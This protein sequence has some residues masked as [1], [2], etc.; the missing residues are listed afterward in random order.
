MCV[1]SVLGFHR[2]KITCLVLK[3]VYHSNGRYFFLFFYIW[4]KVLFLGKQSNIVAYNFYQKSKK[5]FLFY[6]VVYINYPLQACSLLNKFS[7]QIDILISAVY[8]HCSFLS[9]SCTGDGNDCNYNKDPLKRGFLLVPFQAHY[10]ESRRNSRQPSDISVFQS[11][12]CLL[13]VDTSK[14]NIVEGMYHNGNYQDPN[15]IRI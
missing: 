15:Q 1:L 2:T 12:Y 5:P 9:S 3:L 8:Y 7:C 6:S 13:A 4:N 14:N 10:R 11:H